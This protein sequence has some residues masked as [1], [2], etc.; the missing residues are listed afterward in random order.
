MLTCLADQGEGPL[1][2]LEP[3]DGLLHLR[4]EILDAQRQPVETEL[5][6]P[7]DGLVVHAARIDLDRV[8]A[9]LAVVQA[10]ILEQPLH[11]L[12]ELGLVEEG[13]RATA[14]MQLVDTPARIEQFALQAHLLDQ[15]LDVGICAVLMAG[16][17]LVAAAVIAK[18]VTEWHMD[19]DR[20]RLGLG[21][22][23]VA[24]QRQAPV[25]R[26]AE[27]VV[28]L[29]GRWIRGVARAPPVVTLDQ[30]EVEL[31]RLLVH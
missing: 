31:C 28:E 18:R 24:G 3:V 27:A 15:V 4:I 22:I 11:D 7:R 14:E 10:E 12:A 6:Q 16:D 5:G 25:V 20:Q 30:V 19:I 1:L 21:I 2:V 26:L 29:D 9:L 17:D 13:R 8:L 23:A